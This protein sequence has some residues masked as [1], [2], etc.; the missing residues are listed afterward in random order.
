MGVE[1]I[2]NKSRRKFSRAVG[3]AAVWFALAGSLLLLAQSREIPP[4]V[5]ADWLAK[6]LGDPG[7]IV[8][9]IRNSEQYKKG[10]IPG[11]MNVPMNAWAISSNGLSLEL[12]SDDALHDLIG[13]AGMHASS[14]AVVVNR[15]DT[16]FG[17]ADATRVAWTCVL[18]GIPNASVLDGGYNS[19]VRERKTIS[20]EAVN[21]R[22]G[23]CNAKINRLLVASKSDVLNRIGKSILADTRV[24]EDYFGITSKPGH[25]RSAVNLPTPWVFASDGTFRKEDELRAMAAG[26]IGTNRSKE[27]I[28]YCGVGGYASTWWFVLTQILGY[29]NVKLYDGS[30][31]EWLQDPSAPVS[32]Y[33]WH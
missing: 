11:A 30:I 16:D 9:D 10:H 13:K 31:E 23:T 20:T 12:P 27:V 3:A 28:L 26:V 1:R 14:H 22:P 5:S 2:M 33:V 19:W 6:R 29:R 18:A 7:L 25:I 21:A 24:P 8:L 32:T 17:R 15:T 4:I